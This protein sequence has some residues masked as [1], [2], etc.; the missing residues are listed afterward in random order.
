MKVSK[1]VSRT[2]YSITM[3]LTMK[4]AGI[5]MKNMPGSKTSVF[6]G[7][8]T[9]DYGDLAN[10]DIYDAAPYQATGKGKA[11]L[12]NRVSWFFD[13]RGASFTVDTACSSSL[14]A[15]HA[16]C[17]SLRLKESSMV[18]VKRFRCIQCCS[19]TLRLSWVVLI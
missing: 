19:F 4:I 7:C 16:A 18:C 3:S 17:Q 14:Y 5:P 11:M 9:G 2:E 15:L 10:A 1:M 13:L 12:S 6:V 8:F